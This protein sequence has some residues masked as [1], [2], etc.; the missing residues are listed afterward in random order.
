[1]AAQHAAHQHQQQFAGPPSAAQHPPGV[2]VAS[3]M[4]SSIPEARRA[5]LVG[6]TNIGGLDESFAGAK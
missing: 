6:K 4:A 1:L 5:M 3:P 2:P